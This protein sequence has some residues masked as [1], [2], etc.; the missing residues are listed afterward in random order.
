MLNLA[1]I[2]GRLTADPELKFTQNNISVTRFT[3]AV[4]RPKKTGTE[5]QADFITVVAW[6]HTAEFV[7]KYFTKGQLMAVD[8]SIRT[9]SYTD[10]DGVTRRTFD[11]VANNVH[12]AGAK[13][14]VNENSNPTTATAEPANDTPKPY[15]GEQEE[16][17][18]IPC[19][20]DDLPF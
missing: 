17:E 13:K 10:K 12:F 2:M 8:G 9:S 7:C 18:D 4:N 16:F 1:C 11:I 14:A 3:L 5:E 19:A 20:D 15:I 6:R